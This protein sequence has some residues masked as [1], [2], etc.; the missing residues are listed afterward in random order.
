MQRFEYRSAGG[1]LILSAALRRLRS[2]SETAFRYPMIAPYR[3]EC[4]SGRQHVT[5]AAIVALI[6]T[7]TAAADVSACTCV[8]WKNVHEALPHVTAVFYGEVIRLELIPG[9]PRYDPHIKATLKIHSVWQGNVPATTIVYT[10]SATMCGYHFQI[11][12]P[13]LVAANQREDGTLWTGACSGNQRLG[14]AG[15]ILRLLGPGSNPRRGTNELSTDM[16]SNEAISVVLVLLT[17]TL[18]GILLSHVIARRRRA[19]NSMQ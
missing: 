16:S 2:G 7:I 4:M 10:A 18:A 15:E 6:V 19:V 9:P 8:G 14:G 17:G 12:A 13:Y 3:R 5:Q 1:N 11:G